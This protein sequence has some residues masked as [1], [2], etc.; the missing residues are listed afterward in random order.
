MPS[1]TSATELEGA[2]SEVVRGMAFALVE[3]ASSLQ[4]MLLVMV[5]SSHPS[6][7]FCMHTA[8]SGEIVSW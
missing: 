3:A 7:S 2:G 5:M 1:L 6:S 8:P 4:G